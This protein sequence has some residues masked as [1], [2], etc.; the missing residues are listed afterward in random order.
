[1]FLEAN[2]SHYR[3]WG[4]TFPWIPGIHVPAGMRQWRRRWHN[5]GHNHPWRRQH[6]SHHDMDYDYDNHHDDDYCIVDYSGCGMHYDSRCDTLQSI[7]NFFL[8]SPYS[9]SFLLLVVGSQAK[10]FVHFCNNHNHWTTDVW[11]CFYQWI[12]EWKTLEWFRSSGTCGVQ[13]DIAKEET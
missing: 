8:S 5:G 7:F 3:H 10:L 11:R 6:H 13:T 9:W 2:S 4:C 12:N 1:M